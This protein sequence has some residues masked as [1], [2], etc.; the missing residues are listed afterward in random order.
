VALQY[1]NERC[2]R[3]ASTWC[4]DPRC[5]PHSSY[6]RRTVEALLVGMWN[7]DVIP[8]DEYM[9]SGMPRAAADPSHA[10]NPMVSMIDL[11]R[12]WDTTEL[13]PEARY[14][15]YLHYGQ[16]NTEKAIG[17]AL[18][19]TQQ[20]VSALCVQAVGRLVH[21]LNGTTEREEEED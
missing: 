4:F 18:G 1:L 6:D 8:Q 15:L 19:L 21:T 17:A 13:A 2:R 5:D 10:G 7:G 12:A 3:H 16:G 20:A 11:R 9:E 14:A